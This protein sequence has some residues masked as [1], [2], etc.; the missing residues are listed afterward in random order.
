MLSLPRSDPRRAFYVQTLAK[1]IS[2]RY[3][4]S[5]QSEDLEKSIVGFTEAICLSLPR[6]T[7]PP[8]PNIVQIFYHLTLSIYSRA[9]QFRHPDDV[10]YCI[11]YLRYLRGHWRGLLTDFLPSV[12]ATLVCALA[13]QVKLGLGDVGQD[14]EEMAGLCDELFNSDASIIPLTRPI[15]AFIRTVQARTEQSVQGHIPSEK[16]VDCL[17]KAMVCLPDLHDVSYLLALSLLNRFFRAPSNDDYKEAMVILNTIIRFRDPTD[18]PSPFWGAASQLA[19]FL[20]SFRF[21]VDGKPEHLEQAISHF[22]TYVD[23]APLEDPRRPVII[24]QLSWLQG[25]RSHDSKATGNLPRALPSTSGSAKLPSFQDMTDSLPELDPVNRV[26]PTTFSKH[27]NA[28]Q[29]AFTDR[30]S[31][32]ADIEDGVKYCRQLLA[33]YPSSGLAPPARAALGFFF[34]RAFKCT[35]EIE[36]LDKAISAARDHIDT[37]DPPIYRDLSRFRLMSCLSFRLDLLRRVEDLNEL[38][39]LCATTVGSSPLALLGKNTINTILCRWPSIARA[40]GHPSTPTAYE[41]VMSWMQASLTFA[42]TLDIQHSRLVALGDGLRV[43]PLDYASYHIDSGRLKR[44]IE[45]LERGRALLWSEMRGFR[46]SIDQIRLAPSHL[47]VKFVAVNRDLETLTVSSLN[48]VDGGDSDVEGMDPFGHLVMRQRKLLDDRE[49]LISEIQTLP[50]FET[51]LKPPAFDVLRLAASHGP[52]IIINHCSWRSDIIILLHNTHPSLIH[53]S[54]DFYL[55]ASKLQDQILR[56]REKGLESDEYEDTLCFVLKELY[57]LVGR[58]VI[59][60]LNKLNVPEQSRLWWCPTSVFCSLPLHAMGPI[61]SDV[62]PPRYFLDL[63]IPSYTPSLSAL[64]QSRNSAG[65]QVIGKPSILLVAQPDDKM[66]RALREAKAVQA[67][68]TQVTTLFS[69]R[70]TPTKVLSRLRDHRFAHI[71]CH[72]LL[73]PRKPFEASFKLHNEKRLLLLD[74]VRSQLPNAEFAFLSACHTAELTDESI[75]DEVLHLAAAMQFCGFRSVVGTMWAM[76]DTDGRDLARY[77][78]GSLFLDETQ[79]HGAR[80]YERTAEALR[81]AV[82][83]LR[84]KTGITLE[85]WVNYVHYGA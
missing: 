44:A 33:S 74:I 48:K 61:P 8:F 7:T 18:R 46:T 68:D 54:D 64:I 34:H 25:F 28:L 70:A 14:I 83:R 6:N 27:F 85:R 65:S 38:M 58:P 45:T 36:Y 12:T 3:E 39:E 84:R 67:V 62:G 57:E 80:Y 4:L 30:L 21:N 53:T 20:A 52:V 11:L 23:G 42:P 43:L 19:G 31:S 76:A 47:A 40:F 37:I 35:N 79:G 29:A 72:G 1:I 32:I 49:K 82:V 59:E 13:V 10:K 41:D 66:P 77:F 2:E 5:E 81:D 69:A 60:R 16:V 9:E 50:G 17:R 63:Y 73:E 22:R 78:Y 51:F 75:A 56:V 71:V 26:S 15:M 24:E 55:R